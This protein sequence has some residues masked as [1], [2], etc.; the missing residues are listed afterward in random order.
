MKKL[1]AALGLSL[2]TMGLAHADIATLKAT[3]GASGKKT[4][5]S[6]ASAFMVGKYG[7]FSAGQCSA[8]RLQQPSH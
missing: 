8:G 1:I 2:M 3:C 5:D 6:D 7:G 4:G